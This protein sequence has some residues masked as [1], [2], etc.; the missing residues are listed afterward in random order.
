MPYRCRRY[1]I[2]LNL[3]KCIFYVPYRILM[4]DP[5]KIIV[6][7]NLESPRN[8]KQLRATLEDTGYYKKLIKAYA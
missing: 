7:V 3:K 1:Q 6:I 4:V 2:M 8:V 5:V